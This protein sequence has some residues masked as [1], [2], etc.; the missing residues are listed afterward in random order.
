MTVEIISRSIFT[1]VWSRAEI[2]LATLGYAVRQASL[3]RH[4]T[5]CATRPDA[6]LLKENYKSTFLHLLSHLSV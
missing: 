1:K 4:V 3:A 6:G 2:E 5:D